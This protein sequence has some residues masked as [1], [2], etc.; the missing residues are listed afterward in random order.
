MEAIL[1]FQTSGTTPT[2]DSLKLEYGGNTFLPDVRNHS[3][4][5]QFKV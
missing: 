3:Y 5:G 4:N 2:T 1:F